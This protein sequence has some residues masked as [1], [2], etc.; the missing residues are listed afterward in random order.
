MSSCHSPPN[1]RTQQST[2]EFAHWGKDLQEVVGRVIASNTPSQKITRPDRP[3]PHLLKSTPISASLWQP[4]VYLQHASSFLWLL[5]PRLQK[6]RGTIM[7]WILFTI[8]CFSGWFIVGK[9]KGAAA[10]AKMRNP[11]D[12]TR[13]AEKTCTRW[14]YGRKRPFLKAIVVI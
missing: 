9:R 11:I 14:E 6:W 1:K 12:P 5:L 13:T 10:L 4:H 8:I 2:S 7:Q 3:V